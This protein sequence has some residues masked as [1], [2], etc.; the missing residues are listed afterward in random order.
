MEAELLFFM[1]LIMVFKIKLRKIVN[2]AKNSKLN[3]FINLI[4][5]KKWL[6]ASLQTFNWLILSFEFN[7]A[8]K[9]E[10]IIVYST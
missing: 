1:F 4:A 9:M 10:S 2:I 5:N 6:I 3:K 8:L 7:F